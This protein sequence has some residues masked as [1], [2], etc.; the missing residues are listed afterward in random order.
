MFIGTYFTTGRTERKKKKREKA[1]RKEQERESKGRKK[2]KRQP[3]FTLPSRGNP[4]RISNRYRGHHYR[5]ISGTWSTYQAWTLVAPSTGHKL[6]TRGPS[7]L[8]VTSPAQPGG[9]FYELNDRIRENINID[10][11]SD[12]LTAQ[13]QRSRVNIVIIISFYAFDHKLWYLLLCSD[14]ECAIVERVFI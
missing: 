13:R 7:P 4:Y 10:E 6:A 9:R 5:P 1:E 12:W 3:S 8:A 11:V 14:S 2:V